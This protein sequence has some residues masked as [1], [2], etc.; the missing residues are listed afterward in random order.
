M[1]ARSLIQIIGA[2]AVINLLSR[3]VGFFREVLI[4]YHFGTSMEA[5]SVVAAYTIPNFLYIA[6]GGAIATAF[7]SVYSKTEG[8]LQRAFRQTVFTYSFFFFLFVSLAFFLFPEFWIRLTFWGFNENERVLTAGLFRWMGISTMFLALSMF[9]T[10]ILNVHDRFRTSALGPLL[11]NVL[12]VGVA[13]SFYYAAGIQAYAFGALL[14][15]VF[16][17][18]LL[19]YSLRKEN[20]LS[21]KFS[22]RMPAPGHMKRFLF[23]AL[24]ILFGGAT[25]QFYFLI[26]R[27]FAA[28]LADG[29]IAALNYSS[30]FVQLPQTILMTA[31]TTVIYPLIAK[32][33]AA[34][35]NTKLNDILNRGMSLLTFIM[36]PASIYVF[37]YAEE[38]IRLLFEYGE[39]KVDSTK[40]T[41][42]LLKI[43][44]LGM[45]AHAAN[46]YLTRFFYAME[47]PASAIV[48]GLIAVFGVNASIAVL[49]LDRYG[50]EAIAWATTI[51]AY[52][53][54][55]LLIV[56]LA[57]RL[58]LKFSGLGNYLKQGTLFAIL[59]LLLLN[60][61][62]R[63]MVL[64]W[65]LLELLISGMLFIGF[66]I[67][68][69]SLSGV[70][71]VKVLKKMVKK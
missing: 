69:A 67:L 49:F 31:V 3:F 38:L 8:T 66:T 7:I 39:F 58:K 62:D 32:T 14:G 65:D 36:V 61:K 41:A 46:V 57:V 19:F 68:L 44:V 64:D 56:L 17:F 5:D 15:A 28:Q 37:L 55:V 48:T 47:R 18:A 23:I 60:I 63:L 34:E 9:F 21:V 71:E 53:Q 12:F 13:G 16:M 2:V 59:F 27:V 1:K 11:N 50:V 29:A 25:L 26:H 33:I 22:W 42:S 52:V 43:L 24:P 70:K 54:M 10:G 30:K 4:G 40:V 45:L 35:N 51:S 6:A 20:L